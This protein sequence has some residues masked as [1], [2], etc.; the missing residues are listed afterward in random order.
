M[1]GRRV[2][3]HHVQWARLVK[4]H[5]AYGDFLA[6]LRSFFSIEALFLDIPHLFSR[7]IVFSSF[8]LAGMI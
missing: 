7:P 5:R 6:W 2:C 4:G 3:V 8:V 1:V